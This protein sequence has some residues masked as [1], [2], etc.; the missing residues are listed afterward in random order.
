MLTIKTRRTV[1]MLENACVIVI[2]L[3]EGVV[4]ISSDCVA[5]YLL[6]DSDI[7]SI[8]KSL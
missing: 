5:G 8:I 2:A 1:S 3:I 6:V 7:T 4:K